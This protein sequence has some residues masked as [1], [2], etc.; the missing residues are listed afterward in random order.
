MIHHLNNINVIED[1]GE[2][3]TD[4]LRRWMDMRMPAT[5]TAVIMEEEEDGAG[6]ES[7]SRASTLR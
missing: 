1:V 6:L 3:G 2:E 7:T 5:A 4:S